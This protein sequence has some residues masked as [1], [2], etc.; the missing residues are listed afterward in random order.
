MGQKRLLV[1]KR[2]S[3]QDASIEQ[4]DLN[5][6]DSAD[7]LLD[8]DR[9]NGGFALRSMSITSHSN[10]LWIFFGPELPLPADGVNDELTVTFT[11]AENELASIANGTVAVRRAADAEHMA[12]QFDEPHS[13]RGEAFETGVNLIPSSSEQAEW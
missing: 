13:A 4:I 8:L 6:P 5:D 12:W 9:S 11:V 1:I 10:T 2:I 3:D 7:V